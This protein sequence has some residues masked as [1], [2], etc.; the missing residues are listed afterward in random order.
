MNCPAEA[1]GF[2]FTERAVNIVRIISPRRA[3]NQER[4][5]YEKNQ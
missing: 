2:S 4:E 1:F 5:N 3:T